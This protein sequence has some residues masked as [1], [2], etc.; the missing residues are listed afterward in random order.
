MLK[1]HLSGHSASTTSSTYDCSRKKTCVSELGPLAEVDAASLK[2]P[3]RDIALYGRLGWS[4]GVFGPGVGPSV[5]ASIG[6]G[7]RFGLDI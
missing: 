1:G 4:L 5:R 2:F 3:F 6:D 7:P